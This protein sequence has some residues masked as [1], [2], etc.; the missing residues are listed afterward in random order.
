MKS[1]QS[2]LFKIDN[3][4]INMTEHLYDLVYTS[5]DNKELINEYFEILMNL[6]H[7]Q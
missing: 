4:K 6:K 1:I 5:L 3:A 2:K 7:T